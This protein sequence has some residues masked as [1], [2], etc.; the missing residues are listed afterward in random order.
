MFTRLDGFREE[1]EICSDISACN[2]AKLWSVKKA[3]VS[4]R[5]S[6]PVVKAYRNQGKLQFS[7]SVDYPTSM[8]LHMH[9]LQIIKEAE[10]TCAFSHRNNFLFE[11]TSVT[12]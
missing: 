3:K 10:K 4:A 7:Q 5:R 2:R 1:D 9:L 8:T 11:V 6:C 12:G